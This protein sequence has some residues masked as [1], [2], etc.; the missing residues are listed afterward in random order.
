VLAA[1]SACA[2]ATGCVADLPPVNSS[3]R[4][5]FD[6]AVYG[7]KVLDYAVD[8]VS[9]SPVQWWRPEPKDKLEREKTPYLSTV[10]L[11]RKGDFV[12]PV[13]VEVAFQDGTRL[14]DHWDGVDR[15]KKLTYVRNSKVISAEIDPDHTVLL[16][17]DLFD[18]SYTE[19]SNGIP[20]RKFTSLW[21]AAQQFIAQLA[22]WIV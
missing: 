4:P 15:W 5:Y 1:N 20:A 6:Q 3:L 12:L 16:D 11:R 14:R 22:S 9:V 2:G 10:Y 17:V 8:R 7:T 18:N 21:T 13:T 19:K